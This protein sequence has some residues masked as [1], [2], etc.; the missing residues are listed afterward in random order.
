MTYTITHEVNVSNNMLGDFYSE[1]QDVLIPGGRF[2][3]SVGDGLS[4]PVLK[5]EA[6]ENYS[7][8]LESFL[9]KWFGADSI[10]ALNEFNF[11]HSLVNI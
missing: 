6:P 11:K 2:T 10:K 4:Y 3:V 8:Q 5:I 9:E 1:L 7:A